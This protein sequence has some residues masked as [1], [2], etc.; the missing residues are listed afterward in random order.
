MLSATLVK[1]ILFAITQTA[2]WFSKVAECKS[3]SL[4]SR[5]IISAS[6][7]LFIYN[8]NVTWN[9]CSGTTVHVALFRACWTGLK[10]TGPLVMLFLKQWVDFTF[11]KSLKTRF[12]PTS[13]TELSPFAFTSEVLCTLN[14]QER[15]LH[16]LP[17]GGL[18][19]ANDSQ[20]EQSSWMSKFQSR[21]KKR[22]QFSLSFTTF[23]LN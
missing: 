14:N 3:L 6:T 13:A 9:L 20:P 10:L 1:F 16:Q 7:F 22:L 4:F 18:G 23:P 17:A 8:S 19:Q 11:S 21:H 2:N 5:S 15:Q 12:F